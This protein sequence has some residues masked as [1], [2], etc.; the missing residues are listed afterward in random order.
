LA[1]QTGDMLSMTGSTSSMLPIRINGA[2]KLAL[3]SAVDQPTNISHVANVVS[4]TVAAGLMI[5]AQHRSTVTF[6]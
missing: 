3:P 5:H 4:N 1:E 2:A 6:R